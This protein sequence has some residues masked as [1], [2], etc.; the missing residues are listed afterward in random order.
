MHKR[1]KK[2]TSASLR[3]ESTPLPARS[4]QPS[5]GDLQSGS[6]EDHHQR[7]SPA[8]ERAADAVVK[9]A[10]RGLMRLDSRR[11]IRAILRRL[12][13]FLIVVGVV[14]GLGYLFADALPAQLLSDTWDQLIDKLRAA[15]PTDTP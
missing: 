6:D 2:R 9:R 10:T 11:R 5:T 7:A 4:G 13:W 3:A 1:E 15:L 14:G 8:V 12:C